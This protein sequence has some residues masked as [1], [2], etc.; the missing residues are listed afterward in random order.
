MKFTSKLLILV[1]LSSGFFAN[2]NEHLWC[3][4]AS[5]TAKH[6]APVEISVTFD[7]KT[8][9]INV[10]HTS[11]NNGL[12]VPYKVDKITLVGSRYFVRSVIDNGSFPVYLDPKNYRFSYE[13]E[14]VLG[15]PEALY[16]FSGRIGGLIIDKM[17]LSCRFKKK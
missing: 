14:K 4:G 15:F 12:W 16:N 10:Y 3:Y 11:D 8:Y 5:T 9:L 13:V 7:P 6:N 17:D 2:A 1:I